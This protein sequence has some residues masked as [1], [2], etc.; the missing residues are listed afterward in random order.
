MDLWR[1]NM[2]NIA[3]SIH[4]DPLCPFED[5]KKRRAKRLTLFV[6]VTTT[7]VDLSNSFHIYS[8]KKIETDKHKT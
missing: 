7:F 3:L 6:V 1:N 2:Y 4:E 5:F 8:M